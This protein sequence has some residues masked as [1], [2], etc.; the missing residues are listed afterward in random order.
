[1]AAKLTVKVRNPDVVFFDGEADAVSSTNEKGPFD[2]LPM[3]E[4]FIS[5]I[6]DKIV[7]HLGGQKKELS[8]NTGVIRAKGNNIQIF[9]SLKEQDR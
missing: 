9:Y 1:M 8:V 7:I 6:K 4:N 2:I 5:L 3:H